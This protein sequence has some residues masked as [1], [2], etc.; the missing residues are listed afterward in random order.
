MDWVDGRISEERGREMARV[1]GRPD[2]I[3]HVAAM[4]A[5]LVTMRQMASID[6][7]ESCMSGLESAINELNSPPLG[8]L[9]FEPRPVQRAWRLPPFALAASVILMAS[10]SLVG[11]FAFARSRMASREIQIAAVSPTNATESASTSAAST[12]AES[13]ANAG[14]FASAT[15]A[16]GNETADLPS[17]LASRLVIDSDRAVELA[18]EGRLLVRVAPG[19]DNPGFVIESL[20]T[21][22]SSWTISNDVSANVIEAVR[23]YFVADAGV[24]SP[25]EVGPN[26]GRFLVAEMFGPPADNDGGTTSDSERMAQHGASEPPATYIAHLDNSAASLLRFKSELNTRLRAGVLFEALPRPVRNDSPGGD[27]ISVPVIIER[28]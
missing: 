6:A 18:R 21:G 19:V 25:A 20:E 5:N 12:L 15:P 11:L 2:I 24:V 4:K 27:S 7:P 22:D 9:R 3:G 28:R 16:H 13:A 17:R 8:A 14:A 26:Q 10:L 23:G 1:A